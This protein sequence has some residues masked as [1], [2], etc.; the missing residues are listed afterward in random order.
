MLF[1]KANFS[2]TEKKVIWNTF[3][4]IC[5]SSF[6]SFVFSV[7][8]RWS[9]ST[10]SSDSPF[11]S[12]LLSKRL[13]PTGLRTFRLTR[14]LRWSRSSSE[15]KLLLESFWTTDLT[16]LILMWLLRSDDV[17]VDFRSSWQRRSCHHQLIEPGSS[18]TRHHAV[19]VLFR[20]VLLTNITGTATTAGLHSSR[21][22]L[23]VY[24]DTGRSVLIFHMTLVQSLD[25]VQQ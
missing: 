22:I 9:L 16:W 13:T 6:S 8:M 5:F 7:T 12:P 15:D 1:I 21:R 11:D 10:S 23:S 25:R 24:W 18:A 4:V 19:L 3:F 14:R 2:L 17:R 20:L